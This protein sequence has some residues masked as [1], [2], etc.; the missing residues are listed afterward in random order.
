MKVAPR[1]SFISL[2]LKSLI[3]VVFPENLIF[4]QTMFRRRFEVTKSYTTH[5]PLLQR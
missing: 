1:F 3:I 5:K 4:Y 2:I